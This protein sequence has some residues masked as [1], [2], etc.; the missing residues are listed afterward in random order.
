[1]LARNYN[2]LI[3][4][5]ILTNVDDG[6]GGFTNTETKVKSIWAKIS[7]KGTGGKFTDYGLTEFKNP[8][9]FSVRGKN[10]L[11]ITEKHFIKFK[12]KN[13]LIKAIE[14]VNYENL[15]INLYCEEG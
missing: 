9:M 11:D 6:F 15:E 13:F 3:D 2:N 7:T 14:N 10:N 12:G 4:V 8:V 5:Y 1:V